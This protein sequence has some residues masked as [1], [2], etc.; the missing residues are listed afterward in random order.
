MELLFAMVGIGLV[1]LGG[2]FLRKKKKPAPSEPVTV[3]PWEKTSITFAVW[4][5]TGEAKFAD[6]TPVPNPRTLKP[7]DVAPAVESWR[8]AIITTHGPLSLRW[9][10]SQLAD[11]LIYGA[12][13][14]PDDRSGQTV[15][16]VKDDGT[17]NARVARATIAIA[18]IEILPHEIGHALGIT[19]HTQHGLMSAETNETEPKNE[20]AMLLITAYK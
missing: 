20:D 7:Q 8:A 18:K 17:P 2:K 14:L 5:G 15:T 12:S 13:G 9:T 10:D 6:G 11:V 3:I 1:F 4:D 16:W 19:F